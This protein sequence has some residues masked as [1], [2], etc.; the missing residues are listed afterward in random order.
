MMDPE[1]PKK[2]IAAW[3]RDSRR[4]KERYAALDLDIAARLAAEAELL[5]ESASAVQE[6]WPP[7]SFVLEQ[8]LWL[9][10]SKYADT[11]F[12]R[13][14]EARLCALASNFRLRHYSH[15]LQCTCLPAV[16]DDVSRPMA[17]FYWTC[18]HIIKVIG[19]NERP[20]H[21]GRTRRAIARILTEV[22]GGPHSQNIEK[23]TRAHLG[24]RIGYWEAKAIAKTA[25]LAA[26]TKPHGRGRSRLSTALINKWMKDEGYNNNELA[27]ALK[28]SPR[29]VSSLRNNGDYH[30]DEAVTK[31]ANLMERDVE[32]LY[33]A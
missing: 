19:E 25:A 32:D 6:T 4:Q 31:L 10:L 14:A 24:A 1:T 11:V 15:W 26:S 18:E 27:A 30:G 16:V 22:V 9:P 29:V 2:Q 28:T 17:R 8:T 3:R 13:I 33:L 21:I 5:R 7:D 20:E 23:R 12:D